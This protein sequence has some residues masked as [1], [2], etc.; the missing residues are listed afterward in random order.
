VTNEEG[1]S[2]TIVI[3]QYPPIY[4][5]GENSTVYNTGPT[6]NQWGSVIVY[7][8]RSRYGTASSY[9]EISDDQ[10]GRLGSVQNFN[11]VNGS[12]TNNNQNQYTIYVGALD[13]GFAADFAGLPAGRM[14]AIGDPRVS[15][16]EASAPSY[17]NNYNTTYTLAQYRK[18][19]TGE[20]FIDVIAPAY[21]VA[22]SYGKTISMSFTQAEKRCAAY[23]ENGYPAGRW[24]IPTEAEIL[25]VV[26]RS[27][28]GVFPKLFEG[29]YW[30]SSG[31]YYDSQ[32]K[33]FGNSTSEAVRCVYDVWYWGDQKG[34]L[35]F[36]TPMIGTNPNGNV[37]RWGN[38]R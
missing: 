38:P 20:Q 24:R 31:R 28:A 11:N 7:G 17:L 30:T 16:S 32:T 3:E 25:F 6:Q 27:E 15:L 18:T 5:T 35:D 22:S 4:I 9:R 1:F 13:A 26:N 29:A 19:R 34:P 33:K 12:G 14:Y 23:Q 36:G 10:N 2:E 37:E 8:Y 21:K